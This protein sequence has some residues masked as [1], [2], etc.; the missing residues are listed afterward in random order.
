[1]PSRVILYTS[2]KL[3]CSPNVEIVAKKITTKSDSISQG[4]WKNREKFKVFNFF[5]A[6]SA[7]LHFESAI[8]F[9]FS[10]LLHIF[11]VRKVTRHQ[12]GINIT[13]MFS[14]STALSRLLTLK[15]VAIMHLRKAE[16]EKQK[17]SIVQHLHPFLMIIIQS[18]AQKKTT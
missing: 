13:E 1:L 4:V 17:L 12:A 9:F 7:T 10:C 14:Y 18:V 3:S 15:S 8:V 5:L 11:G 16:E 2:L 6:F